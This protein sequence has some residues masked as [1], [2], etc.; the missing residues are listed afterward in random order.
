MR[1]DPAGAP[2][3]VEESGGPEPTN[4]RP[5]PTD[6]SA[7]SD[8]SAV[9]GLAAAPYCAGMTSLSRR[10]ASTVVA[11]TALVV[12]LWP[13]QPAQATIP[14]VVDIY[15]VHA[16]GGDNIST[17]MRVQLPTPLRALGTCTM[18][19]TRVTTTDL[20][21]GLVGTTYTMIDSHTGSCEYS[22]PHPQWG[23]RRAA[24]H[25]NYAYG[26]HDYVMKAEFSY[27]DYYGYQYREFSTP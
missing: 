7:S 27:G 5:L 6:R 12:A 24:W 17:I 10:L 15:S 1:Y 19:L 4:E 23:D 13:A 21:G 16:Y 3:R 25:L 22:P 9:A 20:G 14:V 18:T 11:L 8:R 2:G 26:S